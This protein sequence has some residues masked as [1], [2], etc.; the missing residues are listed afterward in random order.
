MLTTPQVPGRL[1]FAGN[2]T[3]TQNGRQCS[4]SVRGP[5]GKGIFSASPCEAQGVGHPVIT[6]L[7]VRPG[8]GRDR[9]NQGTVLAPWSR[10]SGRA[11]ML[12]QREQGCGA[13]YPGL[14]QNRKEPHELGWVRGQ[15]WDVGKGGASMR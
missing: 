12:G 11:A 7:V 13:G 4:P 6:S 14:S 10:P 15:N 1:L 5:C 8:L 9:T 3:H 2:V